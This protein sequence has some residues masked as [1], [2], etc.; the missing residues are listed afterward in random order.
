MRVAQ[1]TATVHA[2]LLVVQ[3]KF[4]HGCACAV[5]ALPTTEADLKP[6]R[7]RLNE[8]SLV[9]QSFAGREALLERLAMFAD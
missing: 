9:R 4:E 1:Q 5:V 6:T 3:T 7:D 8:G 2:S